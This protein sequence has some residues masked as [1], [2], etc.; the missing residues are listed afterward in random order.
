MH[1]T[2]T[3]P[4]MQPFNAGIGLALE[5]YACENTRDDRMRIAV[6]TGPFLFADDPPRERV[7]IPRSFWKA[8]AF[9]HEET[10]KLCATGYTMSQEGWLRD[11]ELVVRPAH[12]CADPHRR[13]RAARTPVVRPG[14]DSSEGR[15]AGLAAPLTDP[16]QIRFV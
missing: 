6:F 13:H 10:R 14:R 2:N 4:P 9:I 11:E 1:V 16:S 7:P 3:V 8:I 15:R 5:R 12:G